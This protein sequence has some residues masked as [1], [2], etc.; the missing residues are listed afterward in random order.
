MYVCVIYTYIYTYEMRK[1]KSLKDG[2]DDRSDESKG[3]KEPRVAFLTFVAKIIRVEPRRVFV[4]IPCRLGVIVKSI[5][6]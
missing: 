5:A 6:I 1:E 2:K 3:G 4:A